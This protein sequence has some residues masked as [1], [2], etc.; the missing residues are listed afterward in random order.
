MKN[1]L[2]IIQI[3]GLKGLLFLAGAIVCLIAGFIVFPGIVMKS[4]WNLLSSLS[5]AVPS[6]GMIQGI[7][8]WGIIVVG[9]YALGGKKS[10][11]FEFKTADDLSKS[12]LDEVMSR[13]KQE[14]RADM[15]K[16]S[17]MRAKLLEME[18]KKEHAKKLEQHTEGIFEKHIDE[19]I[20]Q[21]LENEKSEIK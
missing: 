21:C 10:L 20:R 16:R 7:L 9:F 5:G 3:N 17:L 19:H 6:I 13:I 1:R 11:F 8:L 15:V 2:N 18:A 12:E 4:G 14:R